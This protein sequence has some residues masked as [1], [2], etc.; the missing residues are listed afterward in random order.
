LI[1]GLL[2]ATVIAV[3]A[4]G[5]AAN[6]PPFIADVTVALLIGLAIGQVLGAR[7]APIRAGAAVAA[8]T[9][10]RAGVVLLGA[11]LSLD[12]VVAIGLPA[13]VVVALTLTTVFLSVLVIARA[14]GVEKS[15]GVLLAV[16]TAVCGNSAIIATAPV[17]GARGREV[18]YA[19]ATIT[20]FGTLAVLLYPVIGHL[21]GM[22]DIAFGLWSGIAVNDTSQV[23][24]A[25]SAY[26]PAALE[27]ATVVKLIRN[28]MMAPLLVLIAWQWASASGRQPGTRAG[29]RRAV[30][31]FVLGFVA[32]AGLRSAGVVDAPLA[33]ILDQAA[34]WLILI[35]LAGVGLSIRLAELR[36]VG[37][38]PLGVGLTAAVAA[39]AATLTAISVLDLGS[40][41]GI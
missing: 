2:L 36:S 15:L 13:T 37:P 30:P 14:A 7:I 33:A 10:L 39:G 18:T 6:L 41:I 26:S 24:A 34:R 40:K 16:G 5:L 22:D 9:V 20:L 31:V 21:I 32:M 4:R 1:P 25:S 17:I 12:Q 8:Q 3:L 23:V 27:V 28:A 11:R 19:V 38:R 35:A 29:L